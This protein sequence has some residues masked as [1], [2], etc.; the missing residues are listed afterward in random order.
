MN[1]LAEKLSPVMS[2]KELEA[3]I[4]DHYQGESQLLTQGAEE[5]LL[6]LKQMRGT[7]SEAE[8]ARWQSICEEYRR[9]QQAGGDEETGVKVVRQLGLISEHMQQLGQQLVAGMDSRRESEPDLDK[10]LS[11]LSRSLE[12][13]LTEGLQS[14]QLNPAVTVNLDSPPQVGDALMAFARI[15][16]ESIVPLVK[17]MDGKLDLDLKTQQEMSRVLRVIRDL[18]DRLLTQDRAQS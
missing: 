10:A 2:D 14:V 17:T 11:E 9:R 13:G 18:Q 4:D 16:E 3:L 6:K 15:F 8:A 7:L 12:T 5:N 1:K